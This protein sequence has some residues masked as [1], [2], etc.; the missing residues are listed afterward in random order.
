MVLSGGR[1][2]SSSHVSV[3]PLRVVTVGGE[4]TEERETYNILVDVNDSGG[5]VDDCDLI[6]VLVLLD[7]A[8]VVVVVVVVAVVIIVLAD[9]PSTNII[10][11]REEGES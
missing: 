1:R 3:L 10:V 5:F 6:H 11:I 8:V 9:H 4:R 2:T 7:V